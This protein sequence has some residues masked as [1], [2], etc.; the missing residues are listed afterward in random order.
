MS[1]NLSVKRYSNGTPL[2][3]MIPQQ[4]ND[5]NTNNDDDDGNNKITDSSSAY[6]SV[7]SF[8]VL[9]PLYVRPFDKRTGGIQP[10]AAFEWISKEDTAD[11]LDIHN[12]SANN[13]QS[14]RGQRLFQCLSA[15]NADVICLQELQLERIDSKGT[16]ILPSWIQP[17]LR[18][19]D[20]NENGNTNGKYHCHLPPQAELEVIAAR[21]VR[22]LDADVAVT[23]AILY[24]SQRLEQMVSKQSSTIHAAGADTHTNTNTC[25]TLHL[26]IIGNE[27]G[28]KPSSPIEPFVVSSVHLDAMDEKKRVGQLTRCLKKAKTLTSIENANGKIIPQNSNIIIAG[29]MNQEF[30]AGS[31]V[32]AFLHHDNATTNEMEE[33]CTNSLRLSKGSRP[34]NTQLEEWT[35]VHQEAKRTVFDHCTSLDRVGT[36]CTRAAYDHDEPE[37]NEA[38]MMGSWRLDH[39]LYT[40]HSFE[41]CAIWATLEDDQ[42]SCAVGLPNYRHGSDHIPIAAVFKCKTMQ[43]LS[44]KQQQD[45]IHSLETLAMEQEASLTLTEGKFG[46]EL[47]EIEKR[48][49]DIQASE[50]NSEPGPAKKRKVKKG[51]PPMEIIEC[52]RKKRLIVRDLKMEQRKQRQE[53]VKTLTNSE[54]LVIEQYFGYSATQ[55]VDRGGC[56]S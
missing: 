29:D 52:M 22:V 43:S 30:F 13:G 5:D 3:D 53:I 16:F 24:K 9:A 48:F 38:Q 19:D 47:A 27:E 54:R 8:N 50:P 12:D 28:S 34:S 44:D 18:A 32:T 41:P 46:I 6:I 1:I 11:I 2:S 20:D 23:C 40:P 26:S 33:Q 4:K 21:N 36:E 10:F 17:L 55:W 39:L 56:I 14:G 25:V 31:C 51:K 35:K 15:C 37:E 49:T 42:E 45:L 7:M